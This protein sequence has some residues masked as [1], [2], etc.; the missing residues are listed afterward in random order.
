MGGGLAADLAEARRRR[1]RVALEG[2]QLMPV[3][4]GVQIVCDGPGE[5]PGMAVEP[6]L[7]RMGGGGQQDAMF[8]LEPGQGLLLAS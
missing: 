5:L 8:G 7:G 2:G 6:G 1:Q 3:P 4:A